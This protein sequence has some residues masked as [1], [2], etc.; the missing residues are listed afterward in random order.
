M[1]R[2]GMAY[3]AIGLSILGFAVGVMFRL[4]ILLLLVGLL[5]PV[6]I[7]FS[8][9]HGFGFLDTVVTVIAAEAIIQSGYF[10]GLVAR[11]VFSAHRMPHIL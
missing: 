5:V 2:A 6:A 1:G 11:A 8:L 3:A 7:I 9:G 4:K 10:L